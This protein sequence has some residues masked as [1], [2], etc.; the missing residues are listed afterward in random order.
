MQVSFAEEEE[1]GHSVPEVLSSSKWEKPFFR[2]WQKGEPKGWEIISL[3]DN[4]SFSEKENQRQ[5]SSQR[6]H[7]EAVPHYEGPAPLHGSCPPP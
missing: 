2:A 6:G 3:S 7:G 5:T 1:A 4:M